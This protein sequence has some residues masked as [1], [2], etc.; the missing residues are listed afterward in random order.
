[1]GE[2]GGLRMPSLGV[3]MKFWFEGGMERVS[4]MAVDRSM[5]VEEGGRVNS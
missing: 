1:M 3:I 4:S 2:N 5:T